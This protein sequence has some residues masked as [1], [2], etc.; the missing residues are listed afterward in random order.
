MKF[1]IQNKIILSNI[2]IIIP[3]LVIIGTIVIQG[4]LFYNIEQ[5][6][7]RLIDRSNNSNLFIQQYILSQQ[8]DDLAIVD[9]FK[10]NAAYLAEQIARQDTRVQLFDQSGEL[11]ADS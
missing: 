10:E 5:T 3:A 4:M 1:T 11:L 7:E 6:E 2:V 9:L 8:S